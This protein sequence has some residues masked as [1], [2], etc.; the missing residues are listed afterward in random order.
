LCELL[1]IADPLAGQL[2]GFPL[3]VPAPFFLVHLSLGAL[4]IPAFD[5]EL[6]LTVVV[7]PPAF[8]R[9]KETGTARPVGL[10]RDCGPATFAGPRRGF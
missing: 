2:I 3:A 1:S 9:A 6:L 5:P 7:V 8:P 10:G 4:A